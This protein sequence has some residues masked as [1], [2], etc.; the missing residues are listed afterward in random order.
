MWSGRERSRRWWRRVVALGVCLVALVGFVPAPAA[1]AVVSVEPDVPRLRVGS[2][3]TLPYV[4][5][6]NRTI[7]DGSRRVSIKGIQARVIEL[8]KVDGGYLLRRELVRYPRQ[9][10]LVFVATNGDR[11]SIAKKFWRGAIKVSKDGSRVVVNRSRLVGGVAEY[12]DTAVLALP[13]T[14]LLW[15]QDFGTFDPGVHLY[16]TDR[17]LLTMINEQAGLRTDVS[18]WMPATGA[19]ETIWESALVESADL[20]AWQWAVRPSDG[21]HTYGVSRIPPKSGSSWEVSEEDWNL[22]SWSTD[23]TL[24]WG[25][26]E[27]TDQEEGYGSSAYLVFRASD[28]TILLSIR[29]V[30]DPWAT[31]ESETALLLRAAYWTGNTLNHQLIRC[32]LSGACSRVGPPSSDGFLAI[33]PA[34][35]RG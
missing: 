3:P 18:W 11:R 21:V 2:L 14:K 9:E 19:V 5:W 30:V 15:A 16:G 20:S 4:D 10:D 23:D 1:Q 13:S 6:P 27:V 22:G 7:V 34:T 29:N 28:G 26:N 33:I 35:R 17:V 31:W 12:A 25:N 24:I 8:H 32:R